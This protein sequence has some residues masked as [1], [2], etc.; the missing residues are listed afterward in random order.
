MRFAILIPIASLLLALPAAAQKSDFLTADE[1]DQLRIVQEPNERLK[2][3]DHFAR[4][5]IDQVRKLMETEKP[6]RSALV[7]DLLEDYTKIIDAIDAVAD[8]ALQHRKTINLGI[9]AVSASEKEIL[10]QLQKIADAKPKDIGRYDFVLRDAM[11]ATQD[12]LELNE[13][14]LGKRAVD[15]DAKEKSEKAARQAV[16]A[17]E[18]PLPPG[19]KKPPAA[20]G[21]QTADAQP[22]DA[23]PKRKPPTLLRPGE[24]ITTPQPPSN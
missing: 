5:R 7:H 15:V 21:A 20:A 19:A 14:D 24:K 12:S 17:P 18:E 9:T 6:G 10:A 16:M 3:Y 2:L 8:D 23:T 1:V 4:Q 22:T 13:E 11:Q